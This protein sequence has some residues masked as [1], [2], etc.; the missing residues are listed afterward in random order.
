MTQKET[1]FKRDLDNMESITRQVKQQTKE[2]I[3]I[4]NAEI[5]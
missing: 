5:T 1:D 3:E 4:L 2:N